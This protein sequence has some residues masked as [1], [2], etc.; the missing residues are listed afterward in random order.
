M[1]L[2]KS[3]S[4]VY[5]RDFILSFRMLR[6]VAYSVRNLFFPS[7]YMLPSFFHVGPE[8]FFNIE[9]SSVCN[10]KCVFCPYKSGFRTMTVATLEWFEPVAKSGIQLGFKHLNLT[11]L[12]GEF[13]TNNKAV[14]II[15]SAKK[16]GYIS[17][18]TYTNGIQMH[19]FNLE[20]LLNSGLTHLYISTP[21][22][23]DEL[24]ETVF[25]VRTYPDFKKSIIQLLE[26]HRRLK[27]AVEIYFEPRSYLTLKEL[28]R[29]E[30]Y[31]GFISDFIGEHVHLSQAKKFFGNWGGGI[32]KSDMVGKMEIDVIPLK[33]LAP[34]K[35]VHP[36]E[37]LYTVA[38][39]AN[40]DV[41]LC[42][43][44]YDST[45]ETEKDSFWIDSLKNYPNL[46]TLLERNSAK[47]NQLRE[48]FV[49]GILPDL[50][51]NCSVYVPVQFQ[52]V[53]SEGQSKDVLE[54]IRSN[55]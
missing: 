52:P 43:C 15:Q 41:R 16:A 45:I 55:P 9:V 28:K 40:G 37:M 48:N 23:S 1:L 5:I 51:K 24:Y 8:P 36:C 32:S 11:P 30:F 13:F 34:F 50:C 38:V 7:K 18:F 31:T 4:Y 10:A 27:S 35:K 42:P 2:K 44:A 39:L 17:I 25:G 49:N 6:F 3:P 54:I 22:F 26:T 29:S 33:S 47:I 46:E 20:A 14:E 19:K 53:K 12:T 21:G